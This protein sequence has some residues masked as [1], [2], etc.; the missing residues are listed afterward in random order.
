MAALMTAMGMLGMLL[1]PT[2]CGGHAEQATSKPPASCP[3]R[4][5]PA[6]KRSHWWHKAQR[7]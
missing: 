5:P 7:R 2:G 4:R 6:P 3:Y 1:A